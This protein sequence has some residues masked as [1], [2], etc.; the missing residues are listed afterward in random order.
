VGLAAEVVREVVPEGADAA[1]E[2]V[3]APTLPDTLRSVRVHGT[4]CFTG[5]L[6]NR[7]IIKGFYPIEYIPIG[8]RLTAYGGEASNLPAEV[9]QR[10]LDAIAAG[11]LKVPTHKVY[12]GLE[13]VRQAHTDMESNA[14]T[15]KLVVRVH[16][17]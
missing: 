16:H 3:G 5:M 4:V 1:L 14:A 8:V 17:P 15:G 6:S 7:W 9:L 12:D 11:H 13:Q 2:L 10:L